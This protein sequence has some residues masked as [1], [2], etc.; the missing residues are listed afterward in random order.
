MTVRRAS[1]SAPAKLNLI[2][3]VGVRDSTGYHQLESLFVKLALADEVTVTVGDSVDD[4]LEV[5]GPALP[6]AGLGPDGDNLALRALRAYRTATGWP[7]GAQLT[8]HKRIPVGG[9]LGGGSADAAGVLRALDALAPHPIGVDRLLALGASL[10]AD[11]PFL[12]SDALLAWGWGRGDR[13]LA[14]PALPPRTVWLIP[15]E[16]GVP[17]ASAYGWLAEAGGGTGGGATLYPAD[18]LSSWGAIAARVHNDFTAVVRPRHAGVASALDRLYGMAAALRSAADREAFAL[19]SGSG[20]T[21]ALVTQVADLGATAAAPGDGDGLL[22]TS[23]SAGVV[24]VTV[25]A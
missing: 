2:L 13:L 17:T 16:V 8:I 15:Q 9:G 11:V 22:R 5:T 20:A 3:R 6:A 1:V 19:M 24:G 18:A 4:R 25:E 12:V 14:L 10:G 7:V 23:T 21:C